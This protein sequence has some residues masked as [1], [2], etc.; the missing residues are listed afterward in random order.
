MKQQKNRPIASVSICGWN[1]SVVECYQTLKEFYKYVRR[2]PRYETIKIC[3]GHKFFFELTKAKN[4]W[5]WVINKTPVP[6]IDFDEWDK[7]C[8]VVS[9]HKKYKNIVVV[10]VLNAKKNNETDKK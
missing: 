9:F 2:L 5:V 6:L 1:Q 8:G 7:C 4:K 10:E 3:F